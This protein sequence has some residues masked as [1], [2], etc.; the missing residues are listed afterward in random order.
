MLE[1]IYLIFVIVFSGLG[2][3]FY[4]SNEGIIFLF[5]VTLLIAIKNNLKISRQFYQILGIWLAYNIA[6]TI[7]YREV[8][9]MFAILIPIKLFAAYVLVNRFKETLFEKFEK[10]IYVFTIISL[11]FFA[12]QVI[13]LDS[14][15][16]FA[17]FF[18]FSGIP[19]K[20]SPN[21]L[22]YTVHQ[23]ALLGEIRNC[24]FTWEPGPFS[25]ML[26]LAIFLNLARTNFKI[27]RN[28]RFWILMTGLG[29][30]QATTGYV[31][32]FVILIWLAIN[33]PTYRRNII[34]SITLFTLVI[35]YLYFTIPFLQEKILNEYTQTGELETMIK[36]SKEQQGQFAPGR[37][38]S[39]TID[40]KD[41]LSNP[42]LGYGGHPEAR[43]MFKTGALVSPIGG[44]GNIMAKYGI[45][46]ILFFILI[47]Y[48]SGRFLAR[49]FNYK[50]AVFWSIFI[51]TLAFGFAIVE[52]PIF[53]AVLF[54]PFLKMD[55]TKSEIV[56]N[57]YSFFNSTH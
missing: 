4:R 46:G 39:F 18:D 42:I 29:S 51:L 24:G 28:T 8:H 54:F 2:T 49:Y 41:F 48:R 14:L 40:L 36:T 26:A 17:R 43:W 27:A 6:L 20:H 38:V 56:R 1:N 7:V 19:G 25:C 5:I 44:L 55:S 45:F 37:F 35:T 21:F 15:F 12:W 13:H 30:T 11:F 3:Q 33:N 9:P 34:I 23:K 22:L 10:I 50:V 53:I 16:N 32:L 52:T 57:D 31:A 47:L